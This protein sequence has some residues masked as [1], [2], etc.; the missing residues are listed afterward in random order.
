MRVNFSIDTLKGYIGRRKSSMED[1]IRLSTSIFPCRDSKKSLESKK[2]GPKYVAYKRTLFGMK[3]PVGFIIWKVYKDG[4]TLLYRI[5][6]KEG[7]RR[8]GIGS[9][10][11]LYSVSNLPCHKK[12]CTIVLHCSI[13]NEVARAFY[14]DTGFTLER[15]IDRYYSNGDPAYE[16]SMKV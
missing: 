15:V 6:V 13:H 14:E 10:L 11:V 12:G 1:V 4:K 7:H 3:Y 9:A 16:F 5:G 2:L 8:Q